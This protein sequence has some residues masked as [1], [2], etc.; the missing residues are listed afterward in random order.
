MFDWLG[1]VLCRV[2]AGGNQSNQCSLLRRAES[3]SLFAHWANNCC[4]QSWRDFGWR[5][6]PDTNIMAVFLVCSFLYTAE[7]GN[8][9]TKKVCPQSAATDWDNLL[10]SFPRHSSF[11][12]INIWYKV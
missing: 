1:A 9:V 8:S 12:T 2:A 10:C 4:H 11:K 7:A 5:L 3:A 6:Q